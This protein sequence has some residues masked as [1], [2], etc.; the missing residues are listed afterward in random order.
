M[1]K[2]NRT[3][4]IKHCKRYCGKLWQELKDKFIPH[5]GNNHHP[6]VLKHRA[7]FAYSLVLVA[8]KVLAVVLPI[9]LPSYSLFSS[10]ITPQNVLELTNQSRKNLNL[11]ELSLNT[12]LSE[13]AQAKAE[14][15]LSSQYFAHTSPSGVTPW[16]WFKKFSY[17]YEYAGENLAVHYTTAESVSDGWMASPTHRANIVHPKYTELGVGVVNGIFEG[18]NST[19]VVQFFGSPLSAVAKVSAPIIKETESNPVPKENIDTGRVAAAKL[20]PQPVPLPEIKVPVDTIAVVPA[21]AEEKPAPVKVVATTPV[22]K[23]IQIPI[24]YDASLKVVPAADN[25]Q[26]QMIITGA[27]AVQA[28]LG[29]HSVALEQKPDSSIW[30]GTIPFDR[31]TYST[32]GEQLVVTAFSRSGGMTTTP[33]AVLAPNA[34]TQQVYAFNQG[35]SKT[36]QLLGFVKIGDLNDK[37]RAFYLYVMVFL[38]VALMLNILIKIRIQHPSVIAHTLFV[39]G[40]SVFLFII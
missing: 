23:P 12:V 25:F 20:T 1:A 19:V 29:S 30:L 9:A 33:L 21:V 14:D 24:I 22:T 17:N 37:V 7:L 35:T 39:I 36:L 18:V 32:Q 16:E 26:V 15:M 31:N 28:Q 10:S 27:N 8:I 13:A 2:F 3:I 34:L 38:A 4:W 6:H 5:E 11:G 40:L